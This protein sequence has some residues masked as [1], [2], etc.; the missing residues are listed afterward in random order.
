MRFYYIFIILFLFSCSGNN[1]KSYITIQGNIQGTS[2]KIIYQSQKKVDYTNEIEQILAGFDSTFSLYLPNS[3]ISKINRDDSVF[4]N[5]YFITAFNKAREINEKT[6]GAFDI[7]VGPLV[8]AWGFGPEG[9]KK[10]D[11]KLIDSLLLLVGMDKVKIVNNQL[12]KE[13]PGIKLDFNAIAQGFS[14]DLV[15]DFLDSMNIKNYLVEIGGEVK[16][17][18][19]NKNG[20]IW[21]IGIDKPIENVLVGRELQTIVKLK[22]KALATSGNYRKFYVENGIKYSHTI[23]PKTGYPERSSL[24]SATVLAN[25]CITADAYATAFMVM[26]LE[27]SFEFAKNNPELEA[28]FI[29][30]DEESNFQVKYTKEFKKIKFE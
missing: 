9:N 12:I 18:G 27:K 24:L 15:C 10:I 11:D 26:G 7:T 20:V 4:I 19:V 1:S 29:Y 28:Y 25:E 13:T 14:V 21:R 3:I 23:N 16:T 2:Y 17:K 5:N 22:D 8:N 30:A 6:N